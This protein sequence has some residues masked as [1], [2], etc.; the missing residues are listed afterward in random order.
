MYTPGP[1]GQRR[2]A[3]AVEDGK[4][5][6]EERRPGDEGKG[7]GESPGDRTKHSEDEEMPEVQQAAQSKQSARCTWLWAE[8]VLL[9]AGGWGLSFNG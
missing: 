2:R 3:S 9:G 8:T 4:Q 6:L 1:R 7:R 5:C